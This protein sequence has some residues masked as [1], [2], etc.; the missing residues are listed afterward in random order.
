LTA[1]ADPLP[2]DLD[3]A[4]PLGLLVTELVTAA[5]ARFGGDRTGEISV[6]LLRTIDTRLALT[7]K[8]DAP[9]DADDVGQ[10]RIVRA[11]VAQVG[12]E[13]TLTRGGGTT[14]TITLPNPDA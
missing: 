2:A 11:L 14:A 13:L 12:G 8:D 3:F 10:S 9:P 7:V 1:Q 6:S 5:F 4:G